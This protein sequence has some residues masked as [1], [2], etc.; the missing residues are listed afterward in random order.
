MIANKVKLLRLSEMIDKD[1]SQAISRPEF[2]SFFKNK[3]KVDLTKRDLDVIFK[4]FD[5]DNDG[6]IS[7]KEFM[8]HL[9]NAI[10]KRHSLKDLR[11][12]Q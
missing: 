11:S 9:K 8:E 6:S 10:N 4:T 2:R 5:K 7:E 1:K 12:S 3:I